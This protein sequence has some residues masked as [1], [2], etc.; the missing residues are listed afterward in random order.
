VRGLLLCG[1]FLMIIYIIKNNV[2]STCVF[3]FIESLI[4]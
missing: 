4:G 1:D 3:G 2:I